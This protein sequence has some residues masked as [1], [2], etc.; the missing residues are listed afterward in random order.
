MKHQVE[1]ALNSAITAAMK[2][3]SDYMA[4]NQNVYPCGFAWVEVS[5]R[6]NSKMGKALIEAGLQKSYQ[7]GKLRLSNRWSRTQSMLANEEGAIAAAQVLS[8]ML[9]VDAYPMSRID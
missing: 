3:T 7:P 4:K 6:S 5:I 2:A 8:D 9:G 1:Q